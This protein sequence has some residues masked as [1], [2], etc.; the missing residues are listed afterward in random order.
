MCSNT[1]AVFVHFA[2]LIGNIY[3]C[4]FTFIRCNTIQYEFKKKIYI[5]MH[6]YRV[7]QL[8]NGTKLTCRAGTYGTYFWNNLILA[9]LILSCL[10]LSNCFI[11]FCLFVSYHVLSNII[12]SNLI[13]SYF[14]WSHL[15]YFY[16]LQEHAK[17][18]DRTINTNN[19]IYQSTIGQR[20]E[21]S[22]YNYLHI[23]EA[24]CP[25]TYSCACSSEQRVGLKIR[26]SGLR[27]PLL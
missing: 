13:L 20:V 26:R 21:M 10:I 7:N 6:I 22:F 11:S 5:Y 25:G 19:R 18:F 23:N 14:I 4:S 12:L 24:Y 8:I 3:I 15:A 1:R 9:Y 16:L 27:F 2:E 17:G